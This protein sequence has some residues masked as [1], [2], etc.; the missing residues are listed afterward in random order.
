MSSRPETARIFRAALPADA[1]AIRSLLFESHLAAPAAG[2]LE[3]FRQ[4]RIGEIRVLVSEQE[5]QVIGVL[6]WRNLGKEAEILDL[7][8]ER[9]HRRQGHASF[10]LENFLK[11]AA[12]PGVEGIFLEVRESN[13]AA[14]ALY[15]KFGF[16]IS[17]RR[18]NYYRN[19]EEHALLMH[20]PLRA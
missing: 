7:A 11:G 8:V 2:D 16:Q 17:G 10:L 5:G 6:E 18:P 9:R 1:P 20:L 15:R 19:P 14:I 13:A 4:S 3:R 12:P